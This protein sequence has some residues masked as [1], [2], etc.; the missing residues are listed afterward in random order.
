MVQSLAGGRGHQQRIVSAP[1]TA[2]A[3]PGPRDALDS[4]P[5]THVFFSDFGRKKI[6][7]SLQR[8]TLGQRCWAHQLGVVAVH[9][10]EDLGLRGH[11]RGV[12]R[13][14]E[15]PLKVERSPEGGEP[16]KPDGV[17]GE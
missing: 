13:L 10:V 3:Q 2:S 17:V 6:L 8:W 9:T 12:V 4:F 11:E 7:L 16:G 1:W 5:C 14:G 15:D